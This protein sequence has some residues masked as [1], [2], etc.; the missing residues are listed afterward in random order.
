MRFGLQHICDSWRDTQRAQIGLTVTY[1]GKQTPPDDETLC[2]KLESVR[3]Q[4][5][6]PDGVVHAVFYISVKDQLLIRTELYGENGQQIAI[7]H[8]KDV[9]D[10]W[11]RDP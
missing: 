6:P 4:P 5:E 2:Y 10:T 7:Y 11:S 8:F 9:T 3:A 1:H